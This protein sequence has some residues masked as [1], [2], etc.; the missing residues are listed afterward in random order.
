MVYSR[1]LR[2]GPVV[3]PKKCH[4]SLWFSH[5]KQVALKKQDYAFRHPD[6]SKVLKN[7][8]LACHTWFPDH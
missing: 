1:V 2:F 5:M 4:E 7:K 8:Q 6:K 3:A